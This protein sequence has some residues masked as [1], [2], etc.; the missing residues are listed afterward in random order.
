MTY[1]F[2]PPSGKV[3]EMS[4]DNDTWT[5]WGPFERVH[6]YFGDDSFLLVDTPGHMPGH[7]GALARTGEDECVMNFLSIRFDS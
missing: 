7:L 4:Y 3:R 5:S 2:H 1:C 6:D